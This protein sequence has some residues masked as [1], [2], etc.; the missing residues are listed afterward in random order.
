VSSRSL[1]SSAKKRHGRHRLRLGGRVY[2]QI[3]WAKLRD[4]AAIAS[5]KLRS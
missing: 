1:N 5:K 4:D 3:V 2:S